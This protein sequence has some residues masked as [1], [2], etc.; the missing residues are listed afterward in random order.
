MFINPKS[1]LEVSDGYLPWTFVSNEDGIK[2]YI[3]KQVSEQKF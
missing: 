1:I 2:E 3:L